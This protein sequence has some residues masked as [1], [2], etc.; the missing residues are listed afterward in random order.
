MDNQQA[1]TEFEK[2]WLCGFFDGEGYVGMNICGNYSAMKKLKTRRHT[3]MVPRLILSNT[4]YAAIMKY[5]DLMN[6]A[7]IGVHIQTGRKGNP[8]HK[9]IYRANI[10]GHKR[11]SKAIP[12]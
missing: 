10:N 1:L 5:S 3:I 9:P 2:G 8:K 7:G 6:R 11:V 12:I 4:D